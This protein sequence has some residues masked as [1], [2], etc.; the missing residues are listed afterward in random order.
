MKR[1]ISPW[2]MAAFAALAAAGLSLGGCESIRD[3]AGLGKQAPDE[4]A[5]TTKAPLIIPP[6]YN[7]RPP[8]PGA[9]PT[10]QTSPSEDAQDAL[11]SAPTTTP[12]NGTFSQAEQQLLTNA[13]AT[14]ADDSIRRKIAA[15]NAAAQDTDQSFT[16]EL[17]FGS[18][19][20]NPNGTPVNA[21]AEAQR[22]DT[23]RTAGQAPA[24]TPQPAQPQQSDTSNNSDSGS[25]LDDLFNW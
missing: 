5:I 18:N 6:D 23:A 24:P 22:I 10:N 20:Q 1:A 3:A 16:D 25:W 21:D 9:P 15:D 8:H 14:D 13:G 19:N 7:L 11:F 4:F 2:Q 17:L 12:P